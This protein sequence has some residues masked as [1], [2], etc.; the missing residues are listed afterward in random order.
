MPSLGPLP[1]LPRLVSSE[2]QLRSGLRVVAVQHGDCSL[3]EIR[4]WVPLHGLDSSE[5]PTALL[6]SQALS[7]GTSDQTRAELSLGVRS[8]GGEL[9]VNADPDRLLITG[10]VIS[11]R[12]GAMLEIIAQVLADAT[13]PEAEVDRIRDIFA[14]QLALAGAAPNSQAHQSLMR[15]LYGGHPYADQVPSPAAIRQVSDARLR[16]FH[17]DHFRPAG[18]VLVLLGGEEPDSVLARATT[19]FGCWTGGDPQAGR[20]GPVDAAPGPPLLVDMPGSTEAL[21]RLGG[22]WA[23]RG[24]REWAA[25]E[26]ANLIF[27]GYF[28][29]RL[30]R[31]LRENKGFCYGPSSS[32]EHWAAGSSFVVQA[33]V[34]SRSTL[35]ALQEINNE[36]YG[37]LDRPPGRLEHEEA[38][39]YACG[40]LLLAFS[41]QANLATMITV[42]VGRGIGACGLHN[43]YGELAGATLDDVQEAARRTMDPGRLVTVISGA[44]DELES[45]RATL[46]AV[47]WDGRTIRW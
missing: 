29:S 12:L 27:G 19:A 2:R 1:Q 32:V 33:N 45:C 25:V 20:P 40:R 39:D 10:S 5:V 44:A 7:A 41:D 14:D 24:R 46:G 22:L 9:R 36:L 38:R 37:M 21:I 35:A 8:L 30:V 15:R 13:Y 4:L 11:S 17:T 16:T 18:A 23:P 26:I 31:S 42:N 3:T 34:P 47:P 43:D 6:G 28:S